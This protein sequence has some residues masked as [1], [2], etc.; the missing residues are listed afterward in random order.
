MADQYDDIVVGSGSAG[1]VLAARLSEDG[2]R[3]VLLVEAGP[4]YAGI[5]ELPSD[6]RNGNAMSLVAHDWK[7]RAEIHD[8]RR[9]RFPR[10]KVLGGSSAVGATIALRGAPGDFDE[11][12][13]LGNPGWAWDEVLPYYRRLEDDLDYSGEFH[14]QG[15]PI[16]I[17]RWRPEEMTAG[18]HAFQEA[19]LSAGFP[20]VK[21]HNHPEST[22]VG[23]IPSNRRDTSVRV[24]TAMAYLWPARTR[25]NLTIAADCLVDRV[26][27]D[28][29]RARGVRLSR[30]GGPVEEVRG[31][32][33][34]LAAGAVGSPMILMRSGIGPAGELRR[35]DIEV[36]VD[37]PGVGGNLIDHPRT[38]VFM[39]PAEGTVDTSEAF[40]QTILRTTA[41]R[42][43]EVNDLQYYMVNHFDLN[44]FPELYMLSGVPVIVGI[45]LVVQRPHSR[46][47]LTLSSADP[48]APPVIDLNFLASDHDVRLLTEGV[49]TCWEIANHPAVRG[50]GEEIVVLRQRAIGNDRMLRQYVITSLDSAYHPVGTARMGPG[51]D[52]GAV[53]D[54][55]GA[56]YGTRGLYV[57]DA[58]IMPNIVRA[59]TNPTSIMIGERIA[60]WLA[61]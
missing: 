15:G 51:G 8:G 38:G 61:A 35:H 11:W 28:G 26:L 25:P 17:R 7:Y 27:F 45:M 24:S 47:R 6:L 30:A 59:N 22:G 29:D 37:S 33:I 9:T 3:R 43:D 20:E 14:G 57:A 10:G 54:E 13:A 16:P 2:T 1:A 18:Q 53:V 56:V 31:G 40:L 39:S 55:R 46:G 21:D 44:L 19:C 23:A 34:V 50:F 58:S 32:R 52:P 4:D 49:R 5:D 42:S 48:A 60:A 36:R 12:A 41:P